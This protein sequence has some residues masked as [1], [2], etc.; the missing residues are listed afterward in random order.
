MRPFVY[1]A[2]ALTLAAALAFAPSHEARAKSA[3][4][5]SYGFD[6]TS[7]EPNED[8]A[9]KMS[10]RDVY[11]VIAQ[12]LDVSFDNRVDIPCMVRT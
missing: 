7:G 10:E 4:E 3:Y 9:A 11:S 1:G 8:P 5:S 12:A 6:R 2:V